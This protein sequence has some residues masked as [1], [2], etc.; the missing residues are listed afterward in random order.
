MHSILFALY[1][2]LDTT[3]LICDF[4]RLQA[5]NRWLVKATNGVSK[6]DAQILKRQLKRLADSCSQQDFEINFANL[7]ESDEWKRHRNFQNYMNQ[8]WF[9]DDIV[10]VWFAFLFVACSLMVVDLYS[11]PGCW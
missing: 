4:H 1:N 7:K 3:S 11:W 5:W 6:Q 9:T 10:K 8:T 2:V